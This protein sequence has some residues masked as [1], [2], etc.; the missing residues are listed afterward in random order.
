MSVSH[1]SR[2]RTRIFARV[3]SPFF[4]VIATIVALRAPNM[5]TLLAQFTATEVWPWVTG[6]FILMGGIAIVAFHQRWRSP[7]AVIVSVLGWLLVARGVVLL[8]FPAAFASLANRMIGAVGAW[9]ATYIIMA[10]IGLY[11]SYV[12]WM[13]TS[14]TKLGNAQHTTRGL[15]RAA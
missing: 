1:Q 8:A 15:P 6:A 14:L 2:T 7:A 9:Q 13:P 4:A 12:G 10:L 11:L 5:A 3:L